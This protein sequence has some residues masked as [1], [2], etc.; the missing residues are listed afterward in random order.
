MV[1][2]RGRRFPYRTGVAAS[3]TAVA[4][5]LL[6]GAAGATLTG[7]SGSKDEAVPFMQP[8]PIVFRSVQDEA[9]YDNRELWRQQ[10]L[11]SY[12]YRL[13]VNCFCPPAV[14]RPVRVTVENGTRTTITPEVTGAEVDVQHLSRY[15][16]VEKVFAL[17]EDALNR[18]ADLVRVTYDPQRGYPTDVYIDYSEQ[19]ADEEVGMEVTELSG[20]P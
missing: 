16:N 4:A 9:L 15:D 10:G 11:S 2:Q 12:A 13:R 7:C 5:V 18:D 19:M 8:R 1:P 3:V 20:T 17:I 14:T 6:L